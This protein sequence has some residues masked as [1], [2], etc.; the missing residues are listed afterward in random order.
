MSLERYDPGASP[1]DR[2][3]LEHE[4]RYA[5]AAQLAT[6]ADVLDVGCGAGLG[7]RACLEAGAKSAALVDCDEAACALA[8]KTL[9]GFKGVEIRRAE[10]ASLPWKKASF[11]LA[12]VLEVLEHLADP[13]AALDQV[14]RVLRPHGVV[15]V[16][17]P[18]LEDTANPHHIRWYESADA[19]KDELRAVFAHVRVFEQRT[20]LGSAIATTKSLP[21]GEGAADYYVAIAGQEKLPTVHSAAVW[22]AA[23]A[24]EA[25]TL[26]RLEAD[27]AHL[28]RERDG[29]KEELRA[30]RRSLRWRVTGRLARLL[31]FA[32]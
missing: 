22:E 17:T 15:V 14:R 6:G 29:L 9:T 18:A 28:Q 19:L 24:Y 20:I 30:M 5:F 7:A 27:I 31:G 2:L 23:G 26:R 13:H 25:A 10:A 11:D 12:L 16:S 3:R 1:S 8:R 21:A 32:E 4:T